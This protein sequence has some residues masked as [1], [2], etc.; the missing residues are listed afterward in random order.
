MAEINY[1]FKRTEKKYILS[2]PQYN[3]LLNSAAPYL[4]PDAFGESTVMSLY[5]DTP[6]RQLIRNSLEKPLYKEKL[7]L[8]SYGVPSDG[9]PVF[10]E[11]KKKFKGTVYKRRIRLPLE[12]ARIYA[13]QGILPED[14]QIMREIDALQR[15]YGP[16]I[17]SVLISCRRTAYFCVQEPHLRLTFDMDIRYRENDLLLEHGPGGTVIL[18]EETCLLEIKALGAMPLWLAEALN[19]LSIFPVSFSKYGTAYQHILKTKGFEPCA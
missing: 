14:S 12:Q 3:A 18:P 9:T 10:L 2:M 4:Q 6:S 13:Q 15:F 1:I 8:R 11:L 19:R 5:F 17:P 7:R 16:L